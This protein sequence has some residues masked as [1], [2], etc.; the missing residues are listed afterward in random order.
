MLTV[1]TTG[2]RL[3][4]VLPLL[5]TTS[6][7]VATDQ[8]GFG[9][10]AGIHDSSRVSA[11]AAVVGSTTYKPPRDALYVSP[12]GEDD[13]AGTAND[14]LATIGVAIDR[15]R[16]GA[17]IVLRAG[18]YHE[19]LVIPAG[20]RLTIQPYPDEAVWLDGSERVRGW[21]RSG[22]AF[23]RSRWTIEFDASPTYDWGAPDGT[24]DGW[25]FLD[26]DHPMAAHPD[27]VWIDGTAQRQVGSAAEVRPGTFFVDDQTDRLYLGS[28]PSQKVVRA[29][30]LTKAISI[31]GA[32]STVRGIGVRRFAPS[33]PHMAAVTAESQDIALSNLV[34]TDNSTTGLHVSGSN[35]SVFR[36][37]VARN[38]MLG[39][40]AT[41][42]DHLRIRRLLAAANNTEHFN[43]SPVAGGMKVGRS[44]HVRVRDSVFRDNR[45]KGLWLDESVYDA[46]VLRNN[47]LRNASHGLSLELSSRLLV[48]DNLIADNALYG[49]KVNDTSRVAI[50]NNTLVHNGRS[51]NI[52]QDDRRAT[53]LSVPGHDPRRPFPDPTMTWVN[54]PVTVRNNV[55]ADVRAGANCLLCVEDYSGEFTAEE[56]RATANGNVYQ[57]DSPEHPVWVVVWSRADDDPAV[58]ET[59]DEFRT[60][61]GQESTHLELTSTEAVDERRRLTASVRLMATAVAEPLPASVARPLGRRAGARHLG[62]WIS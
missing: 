46:M 52:V 29:S 30:T 31:R 35:V 39:A 37:T 8:R 21:K 45:G 41:Y 55:M 62:A 4:L 58:Y 17:T 15:A 34:I 38:G 48:A 44:R 14:P 18:T 49:I 6:A 42:A 59:V 51:I 1:R 20:K 54:G 43:Y 22:K 23:V 53:D 7:A 25:A 13:A 24:R 12:Q 32:G 56:M 28:D 47:L 11:G 26:P 27:Q 2:L 9:P 61:T 60:E 50:W 5:M 3:C 33:V 10:L 57:R 36:V 40:S 19:S 16:S